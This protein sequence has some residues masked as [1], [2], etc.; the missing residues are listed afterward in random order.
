[1][2]SVTD[3]TTSLSEMMVFSTWL[4]NYIISLREVVGQLTDTMWK[5]PSFH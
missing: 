2:V 5:T 3:P 1:M 4:E